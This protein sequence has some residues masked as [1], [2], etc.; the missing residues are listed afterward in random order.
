MHFCCR[1]PRAHWNDWGVI[2]MSDISAWTYY[3]LH[4]NILAWKSAVG[5]ASL[6]STV[7]PLDFYFWTSPRNTSAPVLPT[8]SNVKKNTGV[9]E[10]GYLFH[11]YPKR[12][13]QM[14]KRVC[15]PE[16]A[17]RK[18]AETR[19]F[20][21]STADSRNSMTD[22]IVNLLCHFIGNWMIPHF[23]LSDV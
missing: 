7:R 15:L 10:L 2:K 11:K 8:L 13:L 19:T 23:C 9:S 6:P 14:P 4:I 5:C 20:V 22:D 16:V 17:R 1:L 21:L 3:Y 12:P 18:R